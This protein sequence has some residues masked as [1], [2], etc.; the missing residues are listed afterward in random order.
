MR[1][2]RLAARLPGLVLILVLVAAGGW[3]LVRMGMGPQIGIPSLGGERL[4]LP[5]ADGVP[6]FLQGD[7]RWA[8]DTVGGS[9][10]RISRVG[11]TLCCVSMAFTQLGF[12]VNPGELNRELKLRDGYTSQGWLI[13]DVAARIAPAHLT[14][15]VPA[16]PSFEAIDA[17]LS[18][19]GLVITKI[20]LHDA[21]PHWVLI[22]GKTGDRYLI[23]DPLDSKR[24]I[25]PLDERTSRIQAIRIVGRIPLGPA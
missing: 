19:G 5:P 20:L 2:V 11:C 16:R 9:E 3:L 1:S 14:L 10:E 13:W 8:S 21:V 4:Q 17:A 24:R 18:Q 6:Y 23:K 15:R 25:L 7:S 22:V 12:A